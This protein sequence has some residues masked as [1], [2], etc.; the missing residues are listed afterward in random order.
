MS[1]Q[2]NLGQVI[3][4]SWKVDRMTGRCC[5]H[6]DVVPSKQSCSLARRNVVEEAVKGAIISCN[7]RWECDEQTR[8]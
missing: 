1:E 5:R 3:H 8:V 2:R 7:V 6:E 4:Q